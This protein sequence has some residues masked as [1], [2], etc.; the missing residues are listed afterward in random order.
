[1]AGNTSMKT[2]KKSACID[3]RTN[4]EM[5][6]NR[7]VQLVDSDER[8]ISFDNRLLRGEFTHFHH[9]FW[10]NSR[11]GLDFMAGNTSMYHKTNTRMGGEP[12]ADESPSLVEFM[13]AA[14]KC[15]YFFH[16]GLECGIILKGHPS[17][18]E[19]I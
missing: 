5:S 12:T 2:K 18:K 15:L 8:L 9:N 13:Y 6:P 14:D 7:H 3:F 10:R 16:N 1:M 4:L 11:T 17:E 19:Q